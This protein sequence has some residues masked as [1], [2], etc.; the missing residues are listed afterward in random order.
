MAF[1]IVDEIRS[2]QK[3]IAGLKHQLNRQIIH[4]KVA[5]V[6]GDQVRLD[7]GSD[8]KP[9]MG[10]WTRIGGLPS[11]ANGGGHSQYVKP[12]IGEPMLLI[13]PGGKVGEHSRAFFFGPVG[14]FPSAGAA[15]TD[16][17]VHKAGD[18]TQTIRDGEATTTVGDQSISQSRDGGTGIDAGDK[19]VNIKGGKLRVEPPAKFEQSASFGGGGEGS[20]VLHWSGKIILDGDIEVSGG[21]YGHHIGPHSER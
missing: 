16:G 14:E 20:G 15:E 21:V 5:E 12:G 4:G 7:I 18:V 19:P 6:R 8:G 9:V 2:L 1:D 11:G 13:S 3:Q 10:P 17:Y